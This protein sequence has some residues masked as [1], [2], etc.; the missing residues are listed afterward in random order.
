MIKQ[1]FFETL[2]ACFIAVATMLVINKKLTGS[3][4][5]LL[6]RTFVTRVISVSSF[7]FLLRTLLIFRNDVLYIL[8]LLLLVSGH[9][10]QNV[11]RG[12]GIIFLIGCKLFVILWESGAQMVFGGLVLLMQD[13]LWVKV[14]QLGDG[15]LGVTGGVVSY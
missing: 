5:P 10:F 4:H 7:Y 2:I 14:T 1:L 8:Q 12:T 13:V 9:V 11:W 15:L 6:F 3:W